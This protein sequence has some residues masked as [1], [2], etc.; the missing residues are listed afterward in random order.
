MD[1]SMLEKRVKVVRAVLQTLR[2]MYKHENLNQPSV[3]SFNAAG[4][5]NFPK[6]M[7]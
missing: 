5:E 7:H 3:L 4:S 1:L 2:V 6:S